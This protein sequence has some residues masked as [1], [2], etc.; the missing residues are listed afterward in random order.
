MTDMK[1]YYRL[2][3]QGLCIQCGKPTDTEGIRCEACRKKKAEYDKGYRQMMKKLK[4]C[5][6]CKRVRVYGDETRCPECRNKDSMRHA[7]YDK[8]HR[9]KI[10]IRDRET[11]RKLKAERVAKGLCIWCGKRAVTIGYKSCSICRKKRNDHYRNKYEKIHPVNRDEWS[12]HGWC[13][14]CGDPVMK[15][16]QLCEKCYEQ[17]VVNSRLSASYQTHWWRNANKDIFRKG[18]AS[19]SRIKATS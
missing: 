10:R 19:E 11:K 13:Y 15:G 18:D 1:R 5:T 2:K 6:V 16:K 17:N 9:E 12:E 7:E 14:R 8:R 4:I 3:E